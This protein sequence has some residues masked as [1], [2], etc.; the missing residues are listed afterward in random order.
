MLRN[1]RYAYGIVSI[2]LHWLS[3]VMVT[4]L[5]VSGLWMVD[6]DY[7]SAWYNQAPYLHKS[8]GVLF[9]SLAGIR[10]LWRLSSQ[11]PR[12]E[13]GMSRVERSAAAI[14]HY[15]LYV[16]ML[17]LPVSGFLVS[18]AKGHPVD[19]LGWFEIPVLLQVDNSTDFWS[20]IHEVLAW[21]LVTMVILHALAALKH[22]FINRD[23]TL[24][25]ILGLSKG[26]NHV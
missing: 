14:M 5:F 11:V 17:L 7:Y 4:G 3:V 22:H 18:T 21:L 25:K 16:L 1:D 20:D 15:L 24:L 26:D 19:V 13:K 6:L 10:L 8:M 12:F 9:F 23:K 2:F